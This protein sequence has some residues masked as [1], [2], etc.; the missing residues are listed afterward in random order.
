MRSIKQW[1]CIPITFVI[2]SAAPF[3]LCAVTVLRGFCYVDGPLFIFKFNTFATLHAGNYIL[4]FIFISVGE[5]KQWP[6]IVKSEV[7]QK[8]CKFM[9]TDSGQVARKKKLAHNFRDIQPLNGRTVYSSDPRHIRG[10]I[11]FLFSLVSKY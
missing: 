10:K 2:L 6:L 3:W 4:S 1:K 8:K 11:H 5:K 7:G 9:L